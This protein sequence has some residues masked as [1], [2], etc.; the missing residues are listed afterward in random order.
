MK[1]RSGAMIAL[2]LA[3]TVS[4]AVS[5]GV[6]AMTTDTTAPRLP[7]PVARAEDLRMVPR[8]PSPAGLAPVDAPT[9][10]GI[11]STYTG[12]AGWIGQA[13]VALPG[14]LGGAY[15]GE[16]NGFVTVCADRCARLPVVDWCQCYW[17]TSDERVVDLSEAAW[18][19][20]SDTSRDRGLIR[21]RLT[22]E[23]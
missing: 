16:I 18:A 22:V 5:A 23:G 21:V 13:T 11:A 2:V 14:E 7:T 15:T 4:V 12:T 10:V 1:T 3:A 19:L 6:A 8:L 20:V 17:G 9:V